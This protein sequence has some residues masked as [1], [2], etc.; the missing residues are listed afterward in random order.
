VSDPDPPSFS[1]PRPNDGSISS[2]PNSSAPVSSSPSGGGVAAGDGRGQTFHAQ[3]ATPQPPRPKNAVS[4]NEH[5]PEDDAG[6]QTPAPTRTQTSPS[7]PEEGVAA[8]DAGGQTPNVTDPSHP[9]PQPK[10]GGTQGGFQSALL[11]GSDHTE[12]GEFAIEEV[13]PNLAIG[14]SCGR[15]PKGYPHVDPNEDAVF[16]TTDGVTTILAVADGHHGFDAARAAITAIAEAASAPTDETIQSIVRRLTVTAID[17]VTATVPPLTPPRDTSRTALTVAVIRDGSFATT[18]IGDTAC[19]VATRRRA[20]R[21]GTPTDFLSPDSDPAA[22][23][24][25]TVRLPPGGAVV[26]ASDGFLDF[27]GN[28][29]RVL[30]SASSVH[31]SDG[32]EQLLDAAFSGGA[33]DNI[34]VAIAR[35]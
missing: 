27:V 22:V 13:T 4:P 25:E 30:R 19:F 8:A 18:T 7:P 31:P 3:H 28:P 21:L 11:L 15:F 14:I 17:A 23:S 5:G 1:S 29:R 34:A 12:L 9:S 20:K 2:S 33:G 32:A 26:V 24:V 35:R 16:A 6:G 10:D